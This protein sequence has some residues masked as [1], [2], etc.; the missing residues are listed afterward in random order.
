[1]SQYLSYQLRIKESDSPFPSY[2]VLMS[3]QDIQQYKNLSTLMQ[4][5]VYESAI[6][7]DVLD[8]L[9]NYFTVK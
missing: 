8:G 2:R 7:L 5:L 3:P 9:G 6:Y 1:M 4:P